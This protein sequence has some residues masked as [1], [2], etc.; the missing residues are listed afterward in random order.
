VPGTR[1]LVDLLLFLLASPVYFVRFLYRTWRHCRYLC[2]VRTFVIPCSC[3]SNIEL[4]G[5]WRCGCGFTYRGHVLAACPLCGRVPAMIRCYEC[6]LT[7]LL[8]EPIW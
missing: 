2:T 8:P 6:G 5:T 3:G 4:I 7:T 1:L